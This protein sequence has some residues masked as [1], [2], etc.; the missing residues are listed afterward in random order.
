MQSA[1][2]AGGS[3][4]YWENTL[5][6]GEKGK[7]PA[8]EDARPL[9]RIRKTMWHGSTGKPGGGVDTGTEALT[10]GSL[11]PDFIAG[12]WLKEVVWTLRPSMLFSHFSS[13]KTLVSLSV[14]WGRDHWLLR[15]IGGMHEREFNCST[16][17][18]HWVAHSCN[19]STWELKQKDQ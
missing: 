13:L 5:G 12:K 6:R 19:T 4:R 14:S 7:T 17:R 8:Q 2:R 1:R 10:D 16:L 3:D 18:R 15:V 9:G 11:S